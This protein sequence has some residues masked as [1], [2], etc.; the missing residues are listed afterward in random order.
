MA[1][2]LASPGITPTERDPMPSRCMER[3]PPAEDRHAASVSQLLRDAQEL[4]VRDRP[5]AS[6]ALIR[7]AALIDPPQDDDGRPPATSG[8]LTHWQVIRLTRFIESHL[9]EAISLPRMA[10]EVRL[11]RGHFARA[12]KRSFGRTPHAYL[13]ERRITRAKTMML[14]TKA[15]LSAIAL[16]CGLSDQPHLSRLFRRMTGETPLAWRRRHDAGPRP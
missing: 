3:S 8:G 13:T 1:F 6:R 11:S 16:S 9:G 15:P 2:S 14:R 4:L 7:A 5:A 10:T 12:F